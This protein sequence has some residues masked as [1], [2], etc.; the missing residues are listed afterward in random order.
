MF[1]ASEN[2]RLLLPGSKS[3]FI[4][5]D[6]FYQDINIVI[7]TVFEIKYT[8]ISIRN[9]DRDQYRYRC[10]RYFDIFH[11]IKNFKI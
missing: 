8:R 5:E 7:N 11:K 6:P 1:V 3:L 9:R 4:H 2:R 10:Q